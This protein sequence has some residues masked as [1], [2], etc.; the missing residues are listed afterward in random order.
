MDIIVFYKIEEAFESKKIILD[1]N[2]SKEL[3]FRLFYKKNQ[4]QSMQNFALINE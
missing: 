4:N 3:Y 1:R 2:F